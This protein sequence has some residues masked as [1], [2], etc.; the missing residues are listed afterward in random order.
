M[1]QQRPEN[2]PSTIQHFIDG[3]FVDSSDGDTFAVLNPTTNE[4]YIQ[5]ASGKKAEVDRAVSAAQVAFDHGPWPKM[6]PRQRSR[7]LHK[8]ADLVEGQDKR[9]A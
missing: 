2:L 7:I 4:V 6:L 1:T 3:Q 5:A 9:L 8:V